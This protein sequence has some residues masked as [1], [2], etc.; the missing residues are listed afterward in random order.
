[1]R[2][3]ID[4]L[5]ANN[6]G[7]SSAYISV[8]LGDLSH[9]DQE[10]EYFVLC[11]QDRQR[12]FREL[13]DNYQYAQIRL[14]TNSVARRIL[15]QQIKLPIFLKQNQ[16]DV[17]YS[18]N[19]IGPAF[20]PCPVVIA[21]RN[22]APYSKSSIAANLKDKY[23][24]KLLKNLSKVSARR[25]QKVIFVSEY[26]RDVISKIL[27]IPAEKTVVIYHVPGEQFRVDTTTSFRWRK[28]QPYILSVSSI[29]RYKNYVPLIQAFARLVKEHSVEY[30]LLIAGKVIDEAYFSEMK[31]TILS[32]GIQQRVQLLGEIEHAQIHAL[33]KGAKLFVFPS[34]LETFG[35]T[36]I[37]AMASGIP[38]ISSNASVMPE[39]C[40]DA[41]LYFNP[42]SVDELIRA[43]LNILTDDD[44]WETMR[45]RA[46][47]RAKDFSWQRTTQQTLDVFRMAGSTHGEVSGLKRR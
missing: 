18:P 9:I 19:E 34:Y 11:T 41:A 13:P 1:M 44:L 37:E 38:V 21:I 42:F 29:Y 40:A 22:L 5:A 3:A 16:I 26:S 45:L 27:A 33:Y 32:E 46:V 28:L 8:L 23:R 6:P 25:A 30:N 36:L 7:G 43:M 24:L 2:I 47:E 35:R 4:A 39:I 14:R 15:W 12:W 20:S 17:L 31:R 10:N